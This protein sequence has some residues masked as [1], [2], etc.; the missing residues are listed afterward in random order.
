[1]AGNKEKERMITKSEKCPKRGATK[2]TLTE[3]VQRGETAR[4]VGRLAEP[5]R[6][7]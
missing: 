3:P 4:L 2:S 6:R 1:M 5:P 7:R